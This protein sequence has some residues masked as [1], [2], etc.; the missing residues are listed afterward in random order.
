M[1]RRC[2]VVA[3]LATVTVAL[4]TEWAAELIAVICAAIQQNKVRC[5]G[6]KQLKTYSNAPWAVVMAISGLIAVVCAVVFGTDNYTRNLQPFFALDNLNTYH[7]VEIADN[8]MCGNQ[9]CTSTAM[10]AS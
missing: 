8:I 9:C 4:P 3:A 7:S 10:R 1:I 6:G 5:A 2:C